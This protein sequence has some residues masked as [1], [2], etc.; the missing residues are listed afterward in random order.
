MLK[1]S[2]QGANPRP[3]TATQIALK[4][5]ENQID[6]EDEEEEKQT[7]GRPSESTET[8]SELHTDRS[9]KVLKIDK[10]KIKLFKP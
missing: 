10:T 5:K 8:A 9:N 7:S 2:A 3:P 4:E 6:E 1:L